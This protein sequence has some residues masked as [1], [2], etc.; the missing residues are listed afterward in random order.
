[1]HKE[2]A[3]QLLIIIIIIKYSS[4]RFLSQLTFSKE[5]VGNEVLFLKI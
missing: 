4:R 5:R 3:R 1:M 2:K